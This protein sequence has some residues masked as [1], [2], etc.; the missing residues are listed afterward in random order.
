M[1]NLTPP[2]PQIVYA[3]RHSRPPAIP[4]SL[5]AEARAA[6]TAAMSRRFNINASSSKSRRLKDTVVPVLEPIAEIQE[7]PVTTNTL[8][9]TEPVTISP[10]PTPPE[11]EYPKGLVRSLF[12]GINYETIPN[13]Q[14]SGCIQDVETSALKMKELYPNCNDV[15]VITDKSEIKPTRK[16]ILAAIHWLVHDLKPGQHVFLHYSGHAGRLVDRNGSEKSIFEN[17][18]YPYK[19]RKLQI[20]LDEEIRKELAEK[21]PSGCKCFAVFDSCSG[22]V[23]IEMEHMWQTAENYTLYY[24]QNP[25]ISPMEGK[26][27][28]LTTY[29]PEDIVINSNSIYGT[30]GGSLSAILPQ[31]LGIGEEQLEMKEYMWRI[32]M[33]L[34]ERGYSK[35]PVI[36][37]S[38]PMGPAQHIDLSM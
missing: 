22:G 9:Q 38:R 14:L 5:F 24:S 19:G 20:I 1:S 17:C 32:L 11:P 30:T 6:A 37:S 36:T 10:P 2:M 4:E 8:E 21:I 15:R 29:H 26:V 25:E 7:Q 28:F 23:T 31:I 35:I 33:K 18:I 3:S 12:I 34:K 13:L 16:N 27:L